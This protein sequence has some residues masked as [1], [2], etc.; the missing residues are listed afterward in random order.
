[1][2]SKLASAHPRL[3]VFDHDA[4]HR[5]CSPQRPLSSC[6]SNRLISALVVLQVPRVPW[7]KHRDKEELLLPRRAIIFH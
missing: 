6:S 7:R 2:L 1:V 5:F 3:A 4:A